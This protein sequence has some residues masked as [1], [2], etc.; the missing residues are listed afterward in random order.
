MEIGRDT[1]EP[2][3]CP[4][5]H[6]LKRAMKHT[7]KAA[8]VRQSGRIKSVSLLM[9]GEE[10]LCGGHPH[11]ETHESIAALRPGQ[12]SAV[13]LSKAVACSTNDVGHLEGGP[14]HRFLYSCT[15]GSAICSS[16]LTAA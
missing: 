3:F 10:E 13:P 1:K 4:E 14:A 2:F 15:A 5:A 9:F 12:G 6:F 16:G 7:V 11:K 8:L